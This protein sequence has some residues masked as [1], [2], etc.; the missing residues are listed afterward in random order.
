MLQSIDYLELIKRKLIAK[1][2]TPSPKTDEGWQ[3]SLSRLGSYIADNKLSEGD[4]SGPQLELDIEAVTSEYLNQNQE[5]QKLIDQN[6]T[7]WSQKTNI[8]SQNLKKSGMDALI[9]TPI[10]QAQK[11][12]KNYNF[13]LTKSQLKRDVF[14]I[15]GTEQD[16]L[17]EQTNEE[18]FDD[19]ELYHELLKNYMNEFNQENQADDDG[20]V[21]NNTKLYLLK[22]KLQKQEQQKKVVDRKASKGRKIR[23]VVY[24]K[25]V[26]F[27]TPKENASLLD[28][29]NEIVKC[30]FGQRIETQGEE[31]EQEQTDA[32]KA[33]EE[34][35][36][37]KKVKLS[38]GTKSAKTEGS[39]AAEQDQIALI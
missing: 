6:I 27:M 12:L 14:R 35:A 24:D 8:L 11:A 38:E 36:V 13:I 3:P 32:A 5:V 39:A 29:R 9:Q 33:L 2:F 21:M 28:G 22:R 20:L 4:F 34:P 16:N 7:Q 17:H 31:A 30:L 19:G 10:G 15:L 23:Y 26:N 37:T 18:I 1:S 25:V